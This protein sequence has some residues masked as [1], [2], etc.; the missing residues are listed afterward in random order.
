MVGTKIILDN[1]RDYS[2]DYSELHTFTGGRIEAPKAPRSSAEGA[3]TSAE[4]A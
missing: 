2:K 1:P 3:S 4:F